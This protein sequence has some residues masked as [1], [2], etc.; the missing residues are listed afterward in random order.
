MGQKKGLINVISNEN[1]KGDRVG[2]M[3]QTL[4]A[5]LGDFQKCLPE[6]VIFPCLL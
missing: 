6:E 2:W 4:C 5:E 1:G 3:T